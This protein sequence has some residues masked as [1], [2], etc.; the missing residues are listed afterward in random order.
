MK[1][2]LHFLFIML[3]LLVEARQGKAQGMQFFRISGPAATSITAFNSDGTLIWSNAQ[4]NATYTVQTATSLPAGTNW[5]DYVQLP[6]TNGINANLIFSFNP[7]AGM[8]LIPAGS[9]TMGDTLDGE[10]DA[11]PI[12]VSVSA[13][14]MDKNLVSYSQWLTIF[15]WATTNGYSFDNT[16]TGKATNQPVS[17]VNWYDSV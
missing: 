12:S 10:T 16:G 11:V 9:F 7:P 3:A 15:N 8:V 4:P 6:V 14:F 17:V 2:K 13:M 1:T 5:V